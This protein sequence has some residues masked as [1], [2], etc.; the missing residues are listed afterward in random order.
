MKK[1]L[2]ALT[3]YF[4]LFSFFIIYKIN[5]IEA[6]ITKEKINN[7][8]HETLDISEK[9]YY[10]DRLLNDETYE[11]VIN[12]YD[13]YYLYFHQDK[14]NYCLE[15]NVEI[16]NKLIDYKTNVFFLTPIESMNVF[17]TL[18]IES[19]PTLIY[20][21]NGEKQVYRGSEEISK[22]LDNLPVIPKLSK[23]TYE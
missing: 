9:D 5:I 12:K 7:S 10:N 19:T 4:L 14:C 21:K 17:K 20:V 18:K 3:T 6:E 11:D 13:D 22:Y 23:P 1:L 8:V 15:T 16:D 2:I